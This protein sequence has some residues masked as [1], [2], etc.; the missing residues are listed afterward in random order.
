MINN[1]N[2]NDKNDNIIIVTKSTGRKKKLQKKALKGEITSIDNYNECISLNIFGAP[3][4]T[5]TNDPT[6]KISKHDLNLSVNLF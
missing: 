4:I 2:N 6:R 1:N 3:D 5:V